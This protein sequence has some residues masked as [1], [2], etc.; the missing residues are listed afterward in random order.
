MCVAVTQYDRHENTILIDRTG[1]LSKKEKAK[2]FSSFF[3]VSGRIRAS[4]IG[5]DE[6][7][8]NLNIRIGH[9]LLLRNV[10][11][12]VSFSAR[13]KQKKTI[14]IFLGGRFHFDEAAASIR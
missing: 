9:T 12:R 13:S 11:N 8:D 4:F 3:F 5:D 6:S 7:W 10:K 2:S 1:F 14:G